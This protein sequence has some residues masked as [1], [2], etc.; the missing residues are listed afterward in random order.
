MGCSTSTTRRVSAAPR[1]AVKEVEEDID[2]DPQS[3]PKHS[4]PIY[5]PSADVTNAYSILTA[6][7]RSIK[8]PNG[9]IPIVCFGTE[10]F[11]LCAAA[12][13]LG[14]DKLAEIQFPVAAF[15]IKNNA[16][17]LCCAHFGILTS[18]YFDS[19]DTSRFVRNILNWMCPCGLLKPILLLDF[20][21]NNLREIKTCLRANGIP[22]KIK[23]TESE[24]DEVPEEVIFN[25]YSVVLVTTGYDAADPEKREKLIDY[26][27]AGNGVCVFQVPAPPDQE[28]DDEAKIN[29]LLR[30]YGFAY[31]YCKLLNT[32]SGRISVDFFSSFEKI[33]FCHFLMLTHKFLELSHHTEILSSELDD[34]VTS[35]RYNILVVDNSASEQLIDIINHAYTH[36][37]KTNFISDDGICPNINHSIL[38]L[39]INE[40]FMK[41]PPEKINTTFE[42]VKFPGKT[43]NVE[44]STFNFELHMN[45]ESWTPTGLWLPAGHHAYITVNNPPKKLS[46]QIGSHTINLLS[47]QGPWKRWPYI[48]MTFP[49]H[50]G[51][52]EVVSP[53]GGIVYILV[54]ELDESFQ[55][56]LSI[57]FDGFTKHPRAVVTKPEIYE[58]TKNNE[59][60][61]G[62]LRTKTIIF[63]LPNESLKAI[64]D[65]QVFGDRIDKIVM[66]ILKFMCYNISRPYRIVFDVETIDGH[67]EYTYPIVLL[68]DSINDIIINFMKPT[69]GLFQM[70][71]AI[72]VVS[73]RENY[74]EDTTEKAIAAL[75]ATV[76][77]KELFPGFD[78]FVCKFELPT[79]FPE[80]W[81][82]HS[83]I[84]SIIIP[85]LLN[86]SQDPEA[87]LYNSPE[88]MWIRFVKDL[89]Y[90]GKYN[91]SKLMERAKPIPMNIM[92]VLSELPVPPIRN[93]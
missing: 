27:N 82:I 48:I 72:A 92:S 64:E 71:S 81:V 50:D 45:E 73:I 90:R 2:K 19:E 54:N 43:G 63:T 35:L 33:K 66:M 59:I 42:N 13:S 91:F 62:E 57:S 14:D 24:T 23:N 56:P 36:L 20:P 52:N 9:M 17:I 93:I 32:N 51:K 21:H 5:T 38:L 4:H 85:Q 80:L 74:F 69:N 77:F 6:E 41:L 47:K 84:N 87:V 67:P 25:E 78:P 34:I 86:E 60:P 89:S 16:K 75:V 39:L 40:I 10:A 53:F 26:I 7:V 12:M 28:S 30:E 37:K 3:K 18:S 8:C 58:N 65:F 76:I 49:L 70:I 55:N 1:E 15:S 83:Q 22:F 88:D 44:L 79:L 11:P 29:P 46:V 68:K 31:T 61:W